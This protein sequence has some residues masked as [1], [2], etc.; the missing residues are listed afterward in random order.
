MV[1]FF[2]EE[3]KQHRDTFDA[4]NPRDFVDLALKAEKE[5]ND[6]YAAARMEQVG[7]TFL[8]ISHNSRR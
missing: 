2:R 4:E 3:M 5:D 1:N 6:V 8:K 7:L